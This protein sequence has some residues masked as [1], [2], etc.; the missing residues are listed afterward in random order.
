MKNYLDLV[1]T[2]LIVVTVSCIL[3]LVLGYTLMWAIATMLFAIFFP[4]MTDCLFG[5]SIT[6]FLDSE[7]KV[8]GVE[9][10]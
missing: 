8:N 6:E 10:K 5:D 1:L 7:N 9:E 4:L 2:I 3:N